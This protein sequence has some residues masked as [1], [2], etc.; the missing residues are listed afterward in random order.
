[1][2][3]LISRREMRQTADEATADTTDRAVTGHLRPE[4]TLVTSSKIVHSTGAVPAMKPEAT[5]ICAPQDG[6]WKI[7]V[8][9][10]GRRFCVPKFRHY[11]EYITS[12]VASLSEMGW[13]ASKVSR[14]LSILCLWS[15]PDSTR[16]LR[17][18]F[19]QAPVNCDQQSRRQPGW[20]V[21][22]RLA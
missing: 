5:A 15:T 13:L 2:R 22:Y 18:H 14:Y 7:T 20:L 16:Q 9:F 10:D 4:C 21:H 3:E 19:R 11:V 8:S 17:V 6:R 1:M 12:L